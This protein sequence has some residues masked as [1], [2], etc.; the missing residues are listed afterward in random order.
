LKIK[1]LI[2]DTISELPEPEHANINFN[3]PKCSTKL[4]KSDSSYINGKLYW[5]VDWINNTAIEAFHES[6]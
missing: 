4:A 6:N 1:C 2:C 3:C 5:Y